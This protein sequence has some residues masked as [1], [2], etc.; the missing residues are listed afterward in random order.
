[1]PARVSISNNFVGL[2]TEH[3]AGMRSEGWQKD[4]LTIE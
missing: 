2:D 4:G 3:C 1:M